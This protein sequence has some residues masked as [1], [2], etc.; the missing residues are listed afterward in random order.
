MHTGPS[1]AD[2]KLDSTMT[3]FGC[4]RTTLPGHVHT[5]PRFAGV[6]ARWMPVLSGGGPCTGGGGVVWWGQSDLGDLYIERSPSWCGLSYPGDPV[7]WG[8][9][10]ANRMTDTENITFPFLRMR[11]VMK[12]ELTLLWFVILVDWS[13]QICNVITSGSRGGGPGARAPPLTPQIWRPQYAI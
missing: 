11:A 13:L 12:C 10:P 1:V 6:H 2:T 9:P 4:C 7:W 5:C 3:P 8:P